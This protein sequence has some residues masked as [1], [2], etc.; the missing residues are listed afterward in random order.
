MKTLATAEESRRGQNPV[1]QRQIPVT[2]KIFSETIY[3]SI[4]SFVEMADAY[5]QGNERNFRFSRRWKPVLWSSGFR[6]RL[7]GICRH[8]RA[9]TL[10][11]QTKNVNKSR[12]RKPVTAITFWASHSTRER[13]WTQSEATHCLAETLSFEENREKLRKF[14]NNVITAANW[15][16][17]LRASWLNMHAKDNSNRARDEF[18]V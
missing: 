1:H 13:K 10:E 16:R 17:T 4:S 11:W 7:K 18:H 5:E 6:R 8:F 3:H 15:D 2:L 9:L 12:L 14:P